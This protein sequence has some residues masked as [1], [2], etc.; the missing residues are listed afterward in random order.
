MRV[1]CP[2]ISGQLLSVGQRRDRDR[3]MDEPADRFRAQF[4]AEQR[5][6]GARTNLQPERLER[7]DPDRFGD[8]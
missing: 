3:A 2:G 1:I 8:G 5:G 7:L 6:D 4:G